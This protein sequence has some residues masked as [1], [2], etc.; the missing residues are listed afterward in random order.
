MVRL[1][2][3]S[4]D[5]RLEQLLR[6]EVIMAIIVLAVGLERTKGAIRHLITGTAGVHD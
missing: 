4:S 3:R 5:G 2:A 1:A 6:K